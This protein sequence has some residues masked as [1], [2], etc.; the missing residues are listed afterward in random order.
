MIHV[1]LRSW[2]A[3]TGVCMSLSFTPGFSETPAAADPYLWLEEV[4]GDR[5]LE[6]VR[7]RNRTSQ[8]HLES[9]PGFEPLRARLLSIFDSR[10]RIPGIEKIGAFYYNF[11]RDAQNPRGVWRRTTLEEYRKP[12]PAWETVIDLDALARTEQ[13]NWV[14][15]SIHV[16]EPESE[17]ALVRLSRGGGDAVVVR[18][19]DL[20][21][22]TFLADG[23]YLPEAKSQI[24]W[25]DRDTV[26]VGTDWGPGSMTNSGYPRLV[27]RW[28]RG[29]SYQDAESVWAG[30][31]K[32][33]GVS[34]FVTREP[35]YRREFIRHGLTFFTSEKYLRVGDAW[36]KL[37]VPTD[38]NAGTF[39]DQIM[40]TLRTD[41]T[42]GGRTYPGGSYLT[43]PLADFLAGQRDFFALF[44]PTAR[45]SLESVSS[46]RNALILTE[47]ENVKSRLVECRRVDGQWKLTPLPAPEFGSVSVSGVDAF[48]SDDYFMTVTDFLTP[49]TLWLGTLGQ[50][51][52]EK[53]K[54]QPGY[55]ETAGLVISQHEAV[56]ADG[57]HV[58]YFQVARRDLKL[59]GT[60][61]TLL[62]GYGGFA[63][64][65]LPRYSAGTGAAWL[66]KGY[67]YV[68]ANIRGGGEF[69]P[70]W[71]L[72]ALKEKRQRAYDDFIAIGED[73]VKRKVT[74]P[75][76]L[77]IMGGSNGGLL[78]GVM[79]TQ[80]PDLF[81]AVVCQVPLLD[82]QRYHKLLAGAS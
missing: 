69:G 17:R 52:R 76:H 74:S 40:V 58:P 46:T 12:Q 34:G 56:S 61:P 45:S 28:R 67:V 49:T 7:A 30:A 20:P 64:S 2:L 8:E 80:R 9:R 10:D 4:G 43:M 62:Y 59:D 70:A 65:Q 13:E 16:L 21:S 24:S 71:H 73:L 18:E 82:M 50:E 32:D 54:Q 36:V 51:K 37:E 66:E 57:T 38:A 11:W 42:V 78:M 60:A 39:R 29:T 44:T 41:W 26:Y 15:K 27:K 77:G 81:G 35:G 47:L 3:F 31:A 68:L 25:I 55:F 5:A 23:F 19:F 53:L 48:E 79:I 63:V 72:A 33:I 1:S 75:S 22:K 6:W 14:W